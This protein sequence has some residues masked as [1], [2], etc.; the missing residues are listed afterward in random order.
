[1]KHNNLKKVACVVLI[2]PFFLTACGKDEKV[3][4]NNKVITTNAQMDA[5][6]LALAGEQLVGPYT[7]MLANRVFDQ[8]LAKDPKNQ[9]ANFYKAF[10]KPFM[11]Y[12]GIVQRIRPLVKEFGNEDQLQK[13]L[14]KIP[15]SS[16]KDFITQGG[17]PSITDAEQ[18]QKFLTEVRNGYNE[19]RSYLKSNPEME[20]N[21]NLN[22][23]LF[24]EAIRRKMYNSCRISWSG[25]SGNAIDGRDLS[26]SQIEYLDS[27]QD[28]Y[29]YECDP[30]MMAR[31]GVNAADVKVMQQYAAGIVLY[32]TPY[33]SYKFDGLKKLVKLNME[34]SQSGQQPLPAQEVQSVL[35]S[36]PEFGKLRGDQ[37]MT[38][39]TDLGSDFSAAWK[40]ANENQHALCPNLANEWE[41]KRPN[42]LVENGICVGDK[43][44]SRDNLKLFDDIL[45][46]STRQVIR[47]A[48]GQRVETAV[49]PMIVFKSPIA[50]LRDIAPAS[51]NACG[52]AETLR[53]NSLG[54]ILP[55][56]NAKSVLLDGNCE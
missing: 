5:E 27:N 20:L 47:K 41:V 35:E 28:Y 11:A 49:D 53:D 30:S 45:A 43:F 6:E 21:L 54:R 22:P 15:D 37:S 50:N 38:V 14:N 3:K 23:H 18:A 55:E 48:D 8:A 26:D 44:E 32:L 24:E 13:D 42:M 56:G 36:N 52:K 9:R 10:I 46:G 17:G 7:F 25:G 31:V 34:R 39:V 19:F 33:T 4:E 40:W 29:D 2:L 51:Y 16:F 12:K 1:M